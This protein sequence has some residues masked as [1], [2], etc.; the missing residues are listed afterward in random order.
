MKTIVFINT[1]KLGSSRE[2]IKAADLLG[3][4]TILI[5]DKIKYMETRTEFPDIHLILIADLTDFEAM[6]KT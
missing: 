3:Y 5:T 2:A 1:N 6:K 4:Y